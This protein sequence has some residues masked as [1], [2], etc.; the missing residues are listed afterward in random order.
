MRPEITQH[1]LLAAA[2]QAAVSK[3]RAGVDCV[4]LSASSSRETRLRLKRKA[5][6]P[7]SGNVDAEMVA[8]RFLIGALS[9]RRA[10]IVMKRA[11]RGSSEAVEDFRLFGRRRLRPGAL[12]VFKISTR[13]P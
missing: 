3:A 9:P 1:A 4:G 12:F 8:V 10:T 6:F 5:G 2:L 7:F 11:Q 13:G